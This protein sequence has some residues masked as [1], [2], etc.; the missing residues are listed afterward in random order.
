MGWRRQRQVQRDRRDLRGHR[1]LA[2]VGRSVQPGREA[3]G[4]RRRRRQRLRPGHPPVRF[5]TRTQSP[6]ISPAVST[7]RRSLASCWSAVRA[8]PS[9]VEEKPH[10]PDRHSWSRGTY[11]A[12]S[13]TRRLRSSLDSSSGR[14]VVT[15]PRTTCLPFG[16]KRKGSNPPERSS[17]YSR[18]N[19]STSSSENS[20][21][22]TKS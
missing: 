4:Y 9:D 16:T 17:S 2:G 12:A 15:R 19:P 8:L 21:S 14:L 5:V 20:A 1:L 22:A 7:I 6:Q 13:S 10:W 18:K 11:L 3:A